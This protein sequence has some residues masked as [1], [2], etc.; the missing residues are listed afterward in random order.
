MLRRGSQFNAVVG[1][2]AGYTMAELSRLF[3]QIAPDEIEKRKSTCRSCEYLDRSKTVPPQVG[4]CTGCGCPHWRRSEL[5][6]KAT[7]PLAACPRG[8]WTAYQ[9][10]VPPKPL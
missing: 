6:V 1:K 3:L 9:V 10:T 4:Y 7:M 5:S 8:K 2:I